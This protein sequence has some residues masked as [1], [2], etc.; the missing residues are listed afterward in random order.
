MPLRDFWTGAAT[1]SHVGITLA[2]MVLAGFFGGYYL[3]GKLATKPLLAI[4]G[5]FIGATGGFVY[6]IRTLNRLLKEQEESDDRQNA[7]NG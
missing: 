3:D 5:A 1:Y 4:L 7:E 2:V 6:L